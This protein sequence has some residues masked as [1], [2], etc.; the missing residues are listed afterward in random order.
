MVRVVVAVQSK[1]MAPQFQALSLK[2]ALVR[3]NPAALEE[4][5]VKALAIALTPAIPSPPQLLRGACQIPC[6]FPKTLFLE[7]LD[8]FILSKVAICSKQSGVDAVVAQMLHGLPQLRLPQVFACKA[9]LK[10]SCG[11]EY[12]QATATHMHAHYQEALL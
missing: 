8:A 1:A 3:G 5:T 2:A 11:H 7:L 12:C 6:I 4:D 9:R 10:M